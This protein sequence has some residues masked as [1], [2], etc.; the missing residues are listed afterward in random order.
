M[1]SSARVST[2]RTS[3]L[4]WIT[5][6]LPVSILMLAVPIWLSIS[7]NVQYLYIPAILLAG[8]G[9]LLFREISQAISARVTISPLKIEV[10]SFRDR[11]ELG[12]DEIKAI[13]FQRA[14]GNRGI[15]FLMREGSEQI[16]GRFFHLDRMLPLIQNQLPLEVQDPL[17]YQKLPA[18]Q[19]WQNTLSRKFAN[20]DAS[21]HMDLG[22]P[23][24]ILGIGLLLGCISRWGWILWQDS[25][26]LDSWLLLVAL[27]GGLLLADS[28]RFLD[29]SN[30]E[31]QLSTL[32]S[33]FILKWN[34]LQR[35]YHQPDVHLYHLQD[36][37]VRLALPPT[38]M[39]TGKDRKQAVDLVK[40]KIHGSGIVPR[41]SPGCFFWRSKSISKA[42]RR[43]AHGLG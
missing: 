18:Y 3:P 6:L 14:G 34:Q 35:I 21:Y 19:N 8:V 43:Q 9:I 16:K 2:F 1:G 11:Y 40:Y 37:F 25:Q 42:K 31:I 5:F 15:T 26:V 4:Y 29:V 10:V 13:Q 17:A 30:E 28:F 7:L 32:N 12:W 36:Q 33:K 24:R 23:E 38:L 41:E 39:W 20:T 27:S 22:L